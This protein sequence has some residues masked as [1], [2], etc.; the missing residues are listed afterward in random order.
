MTK[1]KGRPKLTVKDIIEMPEYMNILYLLTR[2]A[3][4]DPPIELKHLDIALCKKPRCNIKKEIEYRQFFN[5]SYKKTLGIINNLKRKKK[6]PL[7]EIEYLK[8]KLKEIKK[9]FGIS[10]LTRMFERGDFADEKIKTK[11]KFG[12]YSSLRDHINT[13]MA[14]GLIKPVGKTSYKVT[15]TWHEDFWLHQIHY[16]ADKIPKEQRMKACLH[17]RSLCEL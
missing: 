11:Y 5:P 15:Q 12:S 9:G 17:L 4:H 14:L 6:I 8:E 2:Y 16:Y 10:E 13:L 7:K 1:K 3:Q